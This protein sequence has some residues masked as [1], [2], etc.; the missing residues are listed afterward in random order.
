MTTSTS[1]VAT[2]SADGPR[3]RRLE[4]HRTE[5][6]TE[7]TEMTRRESPGTCWTRKDR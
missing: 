5:A 1:E 4:G 7:M 6:M 3:Q 2:L